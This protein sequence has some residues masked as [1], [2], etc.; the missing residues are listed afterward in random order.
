MRILITGAEGFIGKNLTRSLQ[1]IRDGHDKRIEHRFCKEVKDI[2]ILKYEKNDH[3]EIL[4]DYCRNCDVVIHLAGVNRPRQVEEFR[5][6]NYDFTVKLLNILNY[7]NNLCPIIFS[8]SV[9]AELKGR[10]EDSLYGKSKKEVEELLI[11]EQRKTARKIFIYRFTNI[12]G[13][14][15]KPN[16]NSVVAT[17]CFNISHNLPIQINNPKTKL[18]L[19]YIDDV[20][21]ELLQTLNLISLEQFDEQLYY[22]VVPEYKITLGKIA[23]VI[24]GFSKSICSTQIPNFEQPLIQKLYSTYLSYL[25]KDNFIY[26]LNMKQ[27]ERGNF[28]EFINTQFSGQISIN[29]TKPGKTKGQHWHHSKNEKFLVISGT[30]VIR[31]R[32]IGKDINGE[33]YTIQEYVVSGERLQVVNIVPGYTHSISNLSKKEDLIT[34][35]WASENFDIEKPDTFF[36]EV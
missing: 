4:C 32:K 19:I 13:K 20:I 14:W 24:K 5:K 31:M 9:Q 11:E 22:N 35:M 30:G 8:S 16:Y 18:K 7:Y 26:D 2:Q 27:D 10:F 33:P 6:G 15:C 36:E 1:E 12:F 17:F 25:S 34:I 29:I 3:L 28:S 21:E 23:Q